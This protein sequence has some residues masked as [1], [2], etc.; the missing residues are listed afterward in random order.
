MISKDALGQ[1][2]ST[3][4]EFGEFRLEAENLSL[5]RN[6]EVIPLAP[7]ACEVLLALVE[8]GGSIIK[9]EKILEKVWADTFVEEANLTHH[10]SAL[11]K[12]LGED[13]TAGNLS[14]LFR[15]AVIV[16]SPLSASR[17]TA[18]RKSSSVNERRSILSRKSRLKRARPVK[19]N[20]S[21]RR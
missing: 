16:L 4:Y 6:S 18:W 9:K 2:N 1:T 12:A 20:K 13:K 19:Q 3:T 8:A 21:A 10:I 14:K 7:K 15:V 11:R 17:K 5:F